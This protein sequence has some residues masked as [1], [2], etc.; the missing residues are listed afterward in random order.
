MTSV[1]TCSRTDSVPAY[2]P[3]GRGQWVMTSVK[4]SFAARVTASSK[5]S[6]LVSE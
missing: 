4:P 5:A 6:A 1:A 3:S 2:T